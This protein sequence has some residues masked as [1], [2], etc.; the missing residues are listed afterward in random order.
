MVSATVKVSV[1][2]T[3]VSVSEVNVS[4]LT[5][6]LPCNNS[7]T[8]VVEDKVCVVTKVVTEVNSVDPGGGNGRKF[9]T[10]F[11]MVV[12]IVNVL[13]SVNVSVLVL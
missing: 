9:S 7:E 2:V 5:R 12:N 10:L 1:L 11:T 3:V 13:T 8:A 4:V 6:V